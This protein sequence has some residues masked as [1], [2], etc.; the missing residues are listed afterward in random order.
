MLIDTSGFFA[1]FDPSDPCHADAHTFLGAAARRVTHSYV[2]AE[3]V[4]LAL[5]RRLPRLPA[6]AF[7]RAIHENPVVEIIDV[8]RGLREEA[9]ELLFRRPDKEWSLCDAVSF[10]VMEA[11]SLTEALTTD[12]H[13]EQAGFVRLLRP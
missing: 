4:P 10:L 3:F 13:F 1:L 5:R 2:L 9:L 8:D 7:V 6:L 12:H 11:T